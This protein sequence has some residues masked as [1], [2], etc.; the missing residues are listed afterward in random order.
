[1]IMRKITAMTLAAAMLLAFTACGRKTEQPAETV[2]SVTSVPETQETTESAMTTAA[3]LQVEIPAWEGSWQAEDTDEHF[4]ISNVTDEG[5]DLLFYHFEE[6]QIEEFKY[7]MEFD[8]AWKTVASE[9]GKTDGGRWE[10]TFNFRGDSIL[11]QSK[12]PDQIY[13][14]TA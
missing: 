3:D 4:I 10:Y 14:R 9:P 11:V 5:F 1:M 7:R 6:G 12:H 8:D 2:P 13:E